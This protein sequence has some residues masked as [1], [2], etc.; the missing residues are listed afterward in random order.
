MTISDL[1]SLVGGMGGIASLIA[2]LIPFYTKN[3]KRFLR[4]I[5]IIIEAIIECIPFFLITHHLPIAI[6]VFTIIRFYHII[7]DGLSTNLN[8]R[9]IFLTIALF[10][11]Q[12]GIFS[13]AIVLIKTK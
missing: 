3:P 6:I 10:C 5:Q 2:I 1:T 9:D 11:L 13:T 12:T 4:I 7:Y 8:H